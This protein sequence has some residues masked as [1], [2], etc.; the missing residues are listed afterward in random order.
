M[1]AK[2]TAK[3]QITIPKEVMAQLPKV[4]YF[5]VELRNG[6][7]ALRP[8]QITTQSGIDTIR[9]KMQQL[10]LSED[11]VTEAVRWARKKP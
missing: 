11:A 4:E 5:D 7:I 2:L 1:L 6:E 10:G 3:N 9:A 8:V